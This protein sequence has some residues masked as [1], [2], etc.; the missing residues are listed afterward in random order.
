MSPLKKRDCDH[1][2]VNNI[3]HFSCKVVSD[4]KL[5]GRPTKEGVDSDVQSFLRQDF[6]SS[7]VAGIGG[8]MMR[9]S[10]QNEKAALLRET[11]AGLP[12]PRDEY[13]SLALTNV[14][15]VSSLL[16]GLLLI[17]RIPEVRRGNAELP[18]H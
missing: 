16:V 3:F 11:V 14:V 12:P 4:G 10:N 5:K 15:V 6:L 9:E 1:G 18:M 2:Y 17:F 8:G 7:L 13:G